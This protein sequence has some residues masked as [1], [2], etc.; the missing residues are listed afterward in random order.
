MVFAYESGKQLR[1]ASCQKGRNAQ[2][3][4]M[5]GLGRFLPFLDSE[6]IIIIGTERSIATSDATVPFV[7]IEVTGFAGLSMLWLNKTNISIKVKLQLLK[8][9]KD[10]TNE[11]RI[12][13]VSVSEATNYGYIKF[14]KDKEKLESLVSGMFYC[15]TPEFYRQS[16]DKGVSDL[17]ES[18]MHSYRKSR[19]DDPISLKIN[20]ATIEGISDLT[21]HQGKL[22]DRWLH[23]WFKFNLPTTDDAF[24]IFYE[25]INSMRKEFGNNFA[26]LPRMNLIK[27][28]ERLKASTTLSVEHGSVKYSSDRSEW[29][30]GCKSSIY[31]YQEE[32]RFVVGECEHLHV[33]PKIITVDK[34]FSDLIFA[35]G[36]IEL[37]DKNTKE[38]LLYLDK[39]RFDIFGGIKSKNYALS[40]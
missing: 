12:R 31:E 34:G 39:D 28:V 11:L 18:C 17:H 36:P 20:G 3:I 14:F 13:T 38:S 40:R 30:F 37:I 25:K 10:Q 23:C 6:L 5:I 27:F 33:E 1:A 22:K 35:T 15:N 8:W 24:E 21:L 7:I 29:A 32:F 2:S 9:K 26:F 16:K 19:G 4:R